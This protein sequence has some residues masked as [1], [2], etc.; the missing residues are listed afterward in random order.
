MRVQPSIENPPGPA[1][2]QQNDYIGVQ[3]FD[4]TAPKTRSAYEALIARKPYSLVPLFTPQIIPAPHDPY[5]DLLPRP[6]SNERL[7]P[8]KAAIIIKLWDKDKRYI[9]N[10]YDL[11]DDKMRLFYD[12]CYHNKIRPSQFAA[13]FPRIL[14]EKAKEYYLHYVSP[15]NDF[16]SAYMKIKMHFDT[17]VNHYYYYTN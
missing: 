12:I 13:V 10:I 17:N 4:Q 14:T 1:N 5:F 7:D 8:T 2:E 9:G 3:N 15:E 16:Y 11:L 6:I